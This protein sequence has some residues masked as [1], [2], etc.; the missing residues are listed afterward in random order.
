M[1]HALKTPETRKIVG[2]VS[3]RFLRGNDPVVRDQIASLELFRLTGLNRNGT[4]GIQ[5]HARGR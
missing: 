5:P 3:P 2:S 4:T 1:L